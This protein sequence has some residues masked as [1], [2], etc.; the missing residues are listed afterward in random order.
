LN[1]QQEALIASAMPD[2][3]LLDEPFAAL[4]AIRPC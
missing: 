4:D 2:L 3:I 1:P